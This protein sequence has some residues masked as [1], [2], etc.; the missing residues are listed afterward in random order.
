MAQVKLNEAQLKSLIAENIK[1][2]LK[3][4]GQLYGQTLGGGKLGDSN[5]FR[6]CPSIKIRWHGEWSDPEL[7]YNGYLANYYEIEDYLVAQ[8]REEG[9]DENDDAAF[10]AFCQQNE[11]EI[12][13]MI[14][15]NG[16]KEEDPF[17]NNGFNESKKM[18][19]NTIK[20]DE[21]RLQSIVAESIKKIVKEGMLPDN[22]Y[23]Y[24]WDEIETQLGAEQM[25]NDIFQYLDSSMLE[26]IIRW[27]DGD[28]DFGFFDSHEDE[29]E[30][31]EEDYA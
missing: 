17:E 13:E 26:Q 19:K 4:N 28:Y 7:M 5:N 3:E 20:L 9:I 15:N 18:K 11:R 1:K 25:L 12:Q 6:G 8:A 16:E 23:A 10:D 14:I 2:Q 30:N 29:N 21:N 22:P 31:D 27:F 24:Y